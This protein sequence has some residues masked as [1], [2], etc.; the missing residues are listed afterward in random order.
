V[1]VIDGNGN[2]YT[3]KATFNKPLELMTF[4]RSN[5][6]IKETCRLFIVEDL[7]PDIIE[8][9][10]SGFDVDPS[11][12]A[13]H[14][15][16]QWF[17][18]RAAPGRVP[19]SYSAKRWQSFVSFPY[20]EARPLKA[21]LGESLERV[22]SW[23]SNSFRKVLLMNLPACCT[24]PIGFARRAASVWMSCPTEE[25]W[26]GIMPPIFLYLQVNH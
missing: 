19:S 2:G 23:N 1:A 13:Q 3:L 8:I 11:F 25:N 20:L 6:I 26:T 10:G 24:A 21:A 12:F 9:L 16:L 4:L 18:A 14:V 22:Q 17:S 7:S 5:A 15:C